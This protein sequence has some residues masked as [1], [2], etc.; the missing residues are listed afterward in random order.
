MLL[1]IRLV[2]RVDIGVEE[3]EV[4]QD[5]EKG[6]DED[7][8]KQVATYARQDRQRQTICDYI[9]ADFAKR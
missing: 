6:E 3:K 5:E 8:E 1:L 2:T 9:M 7:E 4:E